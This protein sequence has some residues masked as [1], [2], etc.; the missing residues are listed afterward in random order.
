MQPWRGRNGIDFKFDRVSPTIYYKERSSSNTRMTLMPAQFDAERRKNPAFAVVDF[1]RVNHA[2]FFPRLA[3]SPPQP[4]TPP[5][6]SIVAMQPT[7]PVD[8]SHYGYATRTISYSQH[9]FQFVPTLRDAH[10]SAMILQ[11]VECRFLFSW[12]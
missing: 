11:L 5:G 2:P 12:R 6:S 3:Y 1:W 10:S 7:T 8:L 9:H 4:V